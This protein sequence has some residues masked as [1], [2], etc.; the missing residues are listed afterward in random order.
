MGLALQDI[1]VLRGRLRL[2]RMLAVLETI[3]L[4]Q[5]EVLLPVLRELMVL[6]LH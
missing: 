1:I 6:L 4:L 5:V 3:V 2:R